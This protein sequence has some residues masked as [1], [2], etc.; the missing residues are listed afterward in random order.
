MKTPDR[1]RPWIAIAVGGILAGVIGGSM[2]RLLDWVQVLAYGLNAASLLLEIE[3]ASSLRR[4]LAPTLGGLLVG[5][6]WWA[7]SRRGDMPSVDDLRATT[8]ARTSLWRPMADGLLQTAL[9]GAGASLGREGAPRLAA[10]AVGARLATRLGL[11]AAQ[12]RTIVAGAAGAGL[13]AAYNVPLAGV[14]FG[15]GLTR[16]WREPGVWTQCLAISLIATVVAWPLIGT[17]PTYVY[18]VDVS[19][20]ITTLGWAVAAIPCCAL[21]GIGFRS[22]S[23]RARSFA[24]GGR[25]RSLPLWPVWA[26]GVAGALT[27]VASVWLPMLPGNGKDMMQA[28]FDASAPTQVFAILL[29]AKPLATAFYLACGARGGL[30]TP[31]LSTGAALGVVAAWAASGAGLDADPAVF[32]LLASAG[33]LAVTQQSPM[34]AAVMAWELTHAPIWTLPL[35]FVVAFGAWALGSGRMER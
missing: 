31:S 34:L 23:V 9:V 33:T 2:V 13:T 25:L 19:L 32:A 29:I 22:L 3:Q 15:V 8:P 12:A 6:G 16:R 30:L 10:A 14:I 27:G 35:L 1:L 24:A 28:A 7:L 26:I 17:Q 5:L 18:P 21:V 4:V 20:D 11:E